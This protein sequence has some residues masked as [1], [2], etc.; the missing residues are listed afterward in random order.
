MMAV[1]KRRVADAYEE[2]KKIRGFMKADYDEL[3]WKNYSLI[4]E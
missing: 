1:A 3:Y 2:K 4:V